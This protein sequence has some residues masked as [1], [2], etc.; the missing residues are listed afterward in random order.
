MS[1][2]FRQY[3][4]SDQ[5]NLIELWT[6]C[7]LVV[8]WNDPSKDIRRKLD[9]QPELLIVAEAQGKI[10]GSVMI[11]YEGH[12]GW[13]NYLAVHPEFQRRGYGRQLMAYAEQELLVMGCPKINLQVRET[14]LNVIAFYESIGYQQYNVISFGKRLIPDN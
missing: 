3:Q 2:T 11:G 5:T 7:G 9:I 10:V 6:E 4:D 8:A 1:L 13:I 12:R 14:N